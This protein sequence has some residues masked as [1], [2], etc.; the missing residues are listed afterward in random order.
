VPPAAQLDTYSRQ[1][2]HK[3]NGIAPRV[4]AGRREQE[5]G[6]NPLGLVFPTPAGK[7]GRATDFSRSVLMPAYRAAGWRGPDGSRPWTWQSLPHVFCTTAL[8]TSPGLMSQFTYTNGQDYSTGESP[9]LGHF[10]SSY[11]VLWM[12]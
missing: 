9:S 11:S 8:A 2:D 7:H 6:T 3:L 1:P 4:G 5:A 12:V 10:W